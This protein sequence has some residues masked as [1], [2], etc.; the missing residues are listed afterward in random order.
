M[1]RQT[2]TAV[3]VDLFDILK[4]TD[5]GALSVSQ[6]HSE[7][8]L[9]CWQ[10]GRLDCLIFLLELILPAPTGH[11]FHQ[12][13]PCVWDWWGCSGVL[14]E[15][16][17]SAT[18]LMGRILGLLFLMF[19]KNC[20]EFLAT[21]LPLFICRSFKLRPSKVYSYLTWGY[22]WLLRKRLMLQLCYFSFSEMFLL[23]FNVVFFKSPFALREFF[24][25]AIRK[26]YFQTHTG[27][28]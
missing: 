19:Q 26:R 21:L 18:L 5:K 12:V 10:S 2:Q 16:G 14:C 20:N 13:Y 6:F 8:D 4:I 28:L 27:R 9:I 7:S 1:N 23:T 22:G 24:M 15:T 3:A 17:K 25:L 11:I